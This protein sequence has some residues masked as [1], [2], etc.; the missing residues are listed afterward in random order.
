MLDERD[1]CPKCKAFHGIK[2]LG[3]LRVGEDCGFDSDRP[4]RLCN[5]PVYA[6][7]TGGPDICPVCEA[8]GYPQS[9][10]VWQAHGL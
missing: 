5:R 8:Y 9:L 2:P 10:E 7:S 6:L 4:C 1:M 3:H